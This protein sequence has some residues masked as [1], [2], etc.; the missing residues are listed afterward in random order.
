MTDAT[1]P[2]DERRGGADESDLPPAPQAPEKPTEERASPEKTPDVHG[3][4]EPA[5]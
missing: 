3:D 1:T 4:P 2:S 5:V